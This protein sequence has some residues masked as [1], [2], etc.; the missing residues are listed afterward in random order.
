M[1]SPSTTR[2]LWPGSA[3]YGRTITTASGRSY[4][5][6]PLAFDAI[7]ADVVSLTAAGAVSL[8][9]SG[10]SDP[11]GQP[12]ANRPSP[13][14]GSNVGQLYMDLGLQKLIAWNGDRWVDP[15][16]GFPV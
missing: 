11:P 15:A 9:L 5:A 8:A 13:G 1:G 10:P 2:M 3:A 16:T 4:V 6:G 7:N 12:L 14:E